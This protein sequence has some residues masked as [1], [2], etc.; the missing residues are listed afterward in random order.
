M[1][2]VLFQDWQSGTGSVKSGGPSTFSMAF[3]EGSI[4]GL[5]RSGV[6]VI[7]YQ[8]YRLV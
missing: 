7:I 2:A 8:E 6:D 3:D 5:E 4:N 1:Y